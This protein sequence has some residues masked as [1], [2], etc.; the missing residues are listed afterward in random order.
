MLSK[1]PLREC[2]MDFFRRVVEHVSCILLADWLISV[3][4]RAVASGFA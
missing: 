2:H 4:H 1:S 3:L